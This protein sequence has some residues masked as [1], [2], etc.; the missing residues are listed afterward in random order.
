M[1]ADCHDLQTQVICVII[2]CVILMSRREETSN[3]FISPHSDFN[4]YSMN[5]GAEKK[6]VKCCKSTSYNLYVNSG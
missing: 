3:R 1:V 2:Y 5:T 6:P 4:K